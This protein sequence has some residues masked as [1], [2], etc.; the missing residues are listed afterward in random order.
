MLRRTKRERSFRSP[1]L[2]INESSSADLNRFQLQ[3]ILKRDGLVMI[4]KSTFHIGRGNQVPKTKSVDVLGTISAGLIG[5]MRYMTPWA[6]A[7]CEIDANKTSE[8]GPWTKNA[9]WCSTRNL[10]PDS[11]FVAQPNLTRNL[12]LPSPTPISRQ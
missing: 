6:P 8:Q 10:G 2:D 7:K 12:Q 9:C 5:S 1:D 4:R 11:I 3:R